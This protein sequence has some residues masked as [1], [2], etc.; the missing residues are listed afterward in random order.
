LPHIVSNYD[1]KA[2]LSGQMPACCGIQPAL[3][4]R[5]SRKL[6]SG[7]ESAPLKKPADVLH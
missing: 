7:R 1:S 6:R 4:L 3:L 5:E 2:A